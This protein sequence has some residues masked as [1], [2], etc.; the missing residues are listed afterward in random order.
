MVVAVT[1][2][3]N[4]Q[5][6][7]KF[8]NAL[9]DNMATTTGNALFNY[10]KIV[11]NSLRNELLNSPPLTTARVNARK[12]IKAEKKSK[13]SSVIKMP[14]SL[15]LL[16]SMQPHYVSLRRGRKINAWAR[17][18]YGTAIVSGRSRVKRGP[19]GG[20]SG[21]IYVTPHPFINKGIEKSRKRL[22]KEL[23]KGVRKAFRKS[24][25]IGG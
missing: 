4:T 25:S 24:R 2:K 10:A 1:I 22:P 11:Q 9:P 15:K 12:K 8:F 21:A 3:A 7:E 20:L 14:L 6:V 5:N 18:Y 13:N 16:D 23:R 17:R 19:R